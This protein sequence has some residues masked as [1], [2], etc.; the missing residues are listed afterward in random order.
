MAYGGK[1]WGNFIAANGM[2]SGRFLDAPEFAVMHDKGNEENFFDR[3]DYQFS[4]KN[5]FH[6]N[7]QYTRSWFQTPNSFDTR[8]NGN[9]VGPT[10][11]RSKIE[12][13]DIAPTYTRTINDNS[14]L[15]FGGVRTQGR[16]QLLSQ[17][18]SAGRPGTDSAGDW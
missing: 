3:V 4:P 6:T 15:N 13:F 1:S 17:Q 5:S 12:T 10:D 9:P 18:Q 2:N 16:V 7:L 8:V 14:V 11:Q